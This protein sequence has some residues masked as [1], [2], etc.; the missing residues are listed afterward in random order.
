MGRKDSPWPDGFVD[1]RTTVERARRESS[2]EGPSQV[3]G[4]T[5]PKGGK[6]LKGTDP[7]IVLIKDIQARPVVAKIHRDIAP[8]FLGWIC[9][10]QTSETLGFG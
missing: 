3:Q 5:A 10:E 8:A 2:S 9:V 4:S 6:G 1:N 7:A